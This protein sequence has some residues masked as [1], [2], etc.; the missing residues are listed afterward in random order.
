M[1]VKVLNIL[2]LILK[3][4]LIENEF[5]KVIY[6]YIFSDT[7]RY[8]IV[9]VSKFFGVFPILTFFII[10]RIVYLLLFIFSV[11]ARTF[12][13]L[14]RF[15]IKLY[16]FSVQKKEELSCLLFFSDR[17]C[18]F[19]W[20]WSGGSLQPKAFADLSQSCSSCNIGR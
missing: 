4:I 10:L 15:F 8:S 17:C 1:E 11:R 7:F 13:I 20:R 9:D 18:I 5:V 6:I 19:D 2:K 16:I 3:K 12:L 14:Q